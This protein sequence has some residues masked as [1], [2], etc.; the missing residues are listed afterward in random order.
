MVEGLP[1]FFSAGKMGIGVILLMSIVF[2]ASTI[3]TYVLLCTVSAT[4]MHRISLGP[5]ERYGEVLSGFFIAAL[6]AVF[7]FFP[8]F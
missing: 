2:A 8:V 1:V 6:G 7:W 4:S 3:G 5:L